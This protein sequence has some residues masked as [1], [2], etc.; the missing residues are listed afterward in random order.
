MRTCLAVSALT[1]QTQEDALEI[2]VTQ[3][4]LV[5]ERQEGPQATPSAGLLLHHSRHG[6]FLSRQLILSICDNT[7]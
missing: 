4:G 1:V 7:A 2:Q 3:P 5:A 6:W